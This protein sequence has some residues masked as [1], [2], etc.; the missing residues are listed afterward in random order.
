MQ[1]AVVLLLLVFRLVGAPVAQWF[2]TCRAA[3]TAAER[4]LGLVKFF[5]SDGRRLMT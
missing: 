5:S 1:E 2:L 3:A 4:K